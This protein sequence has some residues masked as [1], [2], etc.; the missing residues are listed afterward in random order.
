MTTVKSIEPCFLPDRRRTPRAVFTSLLFPFL[1]SRVLDHAFF[2]YLPVDINSGGLQFIIP[3]WVVNRDRLRVGDRID[4][5]V[6]FHLGDSFFSEAIVIW[7]RWEDKEGDQRCGV[8]MDQ[9]V[10]IHYPIFI[11][12]GNGS[13]IDLKLQDFKTSGPLLIQLLKD[14]ILLKKGVRIYFKHLVSY[15]SRM[16]NR[17][18]DDYQQLKT[19]LFQDLDNQIKTNQEKLEALL[20]LVRDKEHLET[21]MARYLDLEEL[22]QMME[23]EIYLELLKSAL[24]TKKVMPMLQAIKTLENRQYSN[25]NAMVMLYVHSLQNSLPSH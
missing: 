20:E 9:N 13:N 21:K 24:G 11:E 2:Q 18:T 14:A 5:H 1:G 12:L 15:F 10:L 4:L 16:V 3:K 7:T 23:S 22:R 19:F 17:S 8:A 25:Y 6:P